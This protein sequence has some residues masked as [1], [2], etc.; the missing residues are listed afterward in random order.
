MS[1]KRRKFTAN[2]KAKVALE[3]AKELK[4]VKELS[5]Q[6]GLSPSQIVKWKSHLKSELPVLFTT[7]SNKEKEKADT[8]EQVARLYEEIG[9]LKMERDYLGKKM[10]Q[11]G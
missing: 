11:Y 6:F 7:G 10:E 3:A 9:R 5:V 4:T 1:K 2:F 8:A